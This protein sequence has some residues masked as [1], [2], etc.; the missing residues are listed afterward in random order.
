MNVIFRYILEVYDTISIGCFYRLGVL[1]K[2]LR[3]PLQGFFGVD[4]EQG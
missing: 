1:L 2:V 3:A 4:M